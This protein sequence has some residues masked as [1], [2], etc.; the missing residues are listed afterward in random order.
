MNNI[1]D[2]SSQVFRKINHSDIKLSKLPDILSN[3]KNPIGEL[4]MM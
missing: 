4:M 2:Q 3:F 1:I